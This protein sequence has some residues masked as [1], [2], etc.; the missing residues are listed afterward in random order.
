M[1]TFGSN[2]HGQLGTGD[3]LRRTGPVR[4]DLSANAQV[5]Q[6]VAGANHCV[7]RTSDG[8]VL[9]FGAYKSGQLGRRSDERFWFAKPDVVPEFGPER[10]CVANWVSAHGDVTLVQYHRQLFTRSEL[11]DCYITA[12]RDTLILAPK[13]QEK[14]FVL[15]RR[16]GN[17]PFNRFR[18]GAHASSLRY[19]ISKI[20]TTATND[21]F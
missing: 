9:T 17:S 6:A 15:L 2:C 21:P 1:Y 11:A 12:S 8:R 7:L 4:L 5:V 14:E 19:A 13:D 20:S 16:T 10:G 3:T 18:L